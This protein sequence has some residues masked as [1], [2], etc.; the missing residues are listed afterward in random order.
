[1]LEIYCEVIEDRVLAPRKDP[2]A[3]QRL[4]AR[5]V[6]NEVPAGAPVTCPLLLPMGLLEVESFDACLACPHAQVEA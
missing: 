2:D 5:G 4:L 3:T 6:L 1:M